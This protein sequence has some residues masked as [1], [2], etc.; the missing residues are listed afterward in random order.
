MSKSA[1][2]L[3]GKTK[4]KLVLLGDQGTGKSSIIERFI[5]DRYA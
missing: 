2:S 3:G 4:H 1:S 5:N